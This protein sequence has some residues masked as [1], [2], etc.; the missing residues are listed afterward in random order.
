MLTLR[1]LYPRELEFGT[2][3]FLQRHP[4]TGDFQLINGG[5]E[6]RF[7]LDSVL[8]AELVPATHVSD[9]DSA[10]WREFPESRVRSAHHAPLTY[11]GGMFT[12]NHGA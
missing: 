2:A 11:D 1:L 5:C 7:N 3:R 6:R 9:K 4:V 12:T 8:V 10:I